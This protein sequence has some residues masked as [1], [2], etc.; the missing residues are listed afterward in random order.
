MASTSFRRKRCG[1]GYVVLVPF[2]GQ[3]YSSIS[4][5]ETGHAVWLEKN[6]ATLERLPGGAALQ[7]YPTAVPR[8]MPRTGLLTVRSFDRLNGAHAARMIL[9]RFHVKL[10]AGRRGNRPEYI[11]LQQ[12][13]LDQFL[14][15]FGS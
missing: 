5:K 8:R 14:R 6:I 13:K 9:Y 3:A 2:R 12:K 1:E 10:T 4:N 11:Y 7:P 15:G